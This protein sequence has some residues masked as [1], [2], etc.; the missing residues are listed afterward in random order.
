MSLYQ[1][2]TC[3]CVENTALA[4]FWQRQLHGLPQLCSACDPDVGAWHG[5]FPQESA[6]DMLRD[7]R[8]FLWRPR[9]LMQLSKGTTIVGIIQ[10]QGDHPLPLR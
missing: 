3:G 2:S 8:G 5:Q 1:C 6:Q 9:E 10:W 7:G 4:N